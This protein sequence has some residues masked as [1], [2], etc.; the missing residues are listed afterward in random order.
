MNPKETVTVKKTFVL[1]TVAIFF[2][3]TATLVHALDGCVDSPE[4]PTAVFGL[5]AAAGSFGLFR[6]RKRSGSRDK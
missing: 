1:A 5:I 6:L 3:T 2:L 4:N